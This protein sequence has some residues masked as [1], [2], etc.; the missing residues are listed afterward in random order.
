MSVAMNQQ[1]I[2]LLQANM[3]SSVSSAAAAATPAN[4]NSDNKNFGTM[5]TKTATRVNYDPRI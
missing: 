1:L 4:I 5:R 3:V 2:Q